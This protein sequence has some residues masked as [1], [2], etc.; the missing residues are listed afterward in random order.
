MVDKLLEIWNKIYE[1]VKTW[2]NQFQPKQKTILICVALGALIAISILVAVLTRK[3]YVELAVCETTKEAGEIKGLLE[4]D[5]LDY[6]VSSDGLSFTILDEQESDAR[7]LLGTNSIPAAGYGIED[8]LN[9]SFTS[10]QADNMKRYKLYLEGQMEEDLEQN[11]AVASA[12]VQLDIPEDNGTLIAQ[13]LES[14]A[15]VVL[16][17][18]E[19]AS[20]N[21][22]IAAGLARFVATALGNDT[23]DKITIIDQN[24]TLWFPIEESTSVIDKADSMMSLKENAETN[25]KNEIKKVL[26]GTNEF[27]QIE[28]ATNVVMDF[29]EKEIT[30]HEYSTND[31]KE[32]GYFSHQEIYQ[33]KSTESSGGVP[34]TDSNSETGYMLETESGADTSTYESITDYLLNEKITNEKKSTGEIVYADST[35]AVTAVKY[36]II[37]EAD[38]KL[39]GFLDGITWDEYKIANTAKTK[40]EVD[41]DLVSVIAMAAGIPENNVSFVAYEETQFIDA[42]VEQVSYKDILQ[43]VL[44]VIILGL[45][46]FVVFMSLRTKREV[47]EEEELSVEDLLQSTLQEE[48]ESIEPEQ[49]SEAG[50]LIDTFVEENPEA[51]AT[52]LRNWLDED[53]G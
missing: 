48:L 3:Q 40:L 20:F 6:K 37:R 16:E 30:N 10:S 12:T 42:V 29:S 23:T 24:G 28:V 38:V 35:V 47:E 33:Q 14:S 53:W 31:G 39:Q 34:G 4:G 11:K 51:V 45:L 15:S 52:L 17:I 5:G 22:E 2:W 8:A 18:K 7:L 19:G 50:K 36:K 46:G 21:A 26:S 1:K 49:K 43:I 13:N 27:A 41:E 25:I 9:G 32:Q 44:I